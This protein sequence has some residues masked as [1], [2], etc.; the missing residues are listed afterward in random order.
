MKTTFQGVLLEVDKEIA[1]GLDRLMR[2]Y[3]FMVRYAFKRQLESETK[4]G[5]LERVLAADTGLPLRYAK[6]AVEEAR[7]LIAGRHEA[8]KDSLELWQRRERKTATR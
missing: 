5:E 7:Q 1:Q 2:K 3:G 6:D 4:V 8:M